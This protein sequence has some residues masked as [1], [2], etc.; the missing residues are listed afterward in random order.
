MEKPNVAILMSVYKS[1]NPSYF[2]EAIKSIINQTY[3]NWILYLCVDGCIPDTISNILNKYE[4]EYSRIVKI[5]NDVNLGLAKSLNKLIEEALK[6]TN[7]YKYF[8]R[9]DSDDICLPMRLEKQVYFMESNKNID[10][11]GTYCKEFGA[12]FAIEKVL[13]TTHEKIKALSFTKCPFVHPTVVFRRRVFDEGNRYPVD[14]HF[15]ED[16][17]FWISLIESGYTLGNLNE[18]LIQYRLE[19]STLKRR[20]GIKK[21]WSEFYIRSSYLVRQKNCNVSDYFKV[22]FRLIFHILPEGFMKVLY[23][24]LR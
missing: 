22:S 7:S 17:S 12:S 19:E 5:S 9:M 3:T 11:S 8:F 6:S 23:K 16:M 13:P 24:K 20:L 4:C 18:Y 15:T 21:G 1:D 14:T 2:E 10:V